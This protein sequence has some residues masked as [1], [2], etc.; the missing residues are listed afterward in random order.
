MASHKEDEFNYIQP[1]VGQLL[2]SVL[3]IHG[4]VIIKHASYISG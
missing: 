4:L 2:I 3:F 1:K